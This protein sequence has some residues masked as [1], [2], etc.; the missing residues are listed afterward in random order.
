MKKIFIALSFFMS[1]GLLLNAQTQKIGYVNSDE[2]IAAMP[3]TN[4]MYAQLD[5][6]QKLLETNINKMVDQY[7]KDV[8]LL[9]SSYNSLSEAVRDAFQRN[10]ADQESKIQAYRESAQSELADLQDKL[11]APIYD[12]AKKAI[13]EVAT[14]RQYAYVFDLS[15]GTLLVYPPGDDLTKA[16]KLHLGI[17]N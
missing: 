11:L 9:D 8:A 7:I 6:R 1:T 10:I 13:N 4:N 3:E 2:I 15:S 14:E 16:V 5:A 17:T 12:K